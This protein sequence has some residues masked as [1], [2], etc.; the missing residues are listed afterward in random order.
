MLGCWVWLWL[1]FKVFFVLK[2]IKMIFFYF[3]KII[4][5]ISASKQSKTYEKIFFFI[6]FG[7]F[8]LFFHMF[9]IVLMRW[10]PKKIKF[11]W[12][13]VQIAFP[14]DSSWI[15]I[16]QKCLRNFGFIFF[17]IIFS[18]I[19]LI[20]WDFNN[21]RFFLYFVFLFRLCKIMDSNL[22]KHTHTHI[23]AKKK[24]GISNI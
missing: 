19:L 13:A 22:K 2:Y 20:I 21:I 17:K 1:L 10:S 7:S 6:C 24:V 23:I 18:L 14:N 5:E 3:K 9:C 12:N 11:L 16:S 4:L 15:L 8:W